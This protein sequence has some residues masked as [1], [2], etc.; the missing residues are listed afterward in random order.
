M[1]EIVLRS[2]YLHSKYSLWHIFVSCKKI[3]FSSEDIPY[4][5]VY[6]IFTKA[7]DATDLV[8]CWKLII[9]RLFPS[10][11]PELQC[12]HVTAVPDYLIRPCVCLALVPL[13]C[14]VLAW[15]HGVTHDLFACSD[16]VLVFSL[17]R[18]AWLCASFDT[19][20]MSHQ[21]GLLIPTL[22]SLIIQHFSTVSF[23][24]CVCVIMSL[25]YS[26]DTLTVSL[27]RVHSVSLPLAWW[28]R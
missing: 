20:S 6:F 5:I 18:W 17:K 8:H 22:R 10:C 11:T 9:P 24:V 27:L 3:M 1:N 4:F 13:G 16:S 12:S 19:T 2:I 26:S 23:P 15:Q 7:V 21:S 28:S 14:I 25:S